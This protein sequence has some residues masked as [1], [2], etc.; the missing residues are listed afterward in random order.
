M[1][2][3]KIGYQ[4]MT[5][6]R[7]TILFGT[8]RHLII[9]F[10]AIILWAI[11]FRQSTTIGNYTFSAIIAYYIMVEIIDIFYTTTAGRLMARDINRGDLSNYLVKPMSYWGYLLGYS[12][13]SMTSYVSLS[14]LLLIGV[15]IIWPS[16]MLIQTNPFYSIATI[17]S[18]FLSALI[19]FQIFYLVGCLTFWIS[20]TN[21]FRSGIKQLLGVFGG[22][23]VPLSFFPGWANTLLAFTPFPLLF[24]SV[25]SIYQGRISAGEIIT[26]LGKELGWL[27]ILTAISKVIWDK[28]LQN[29]G[30]YGK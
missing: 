13:G 17:L 18:I 5:I 16:F 26:N 10:M 11:L 27:I 1:A 21:H 28:G 14:F 23:W 12:F 19:Y 30:A 6:Y 24:T 8:L 22:K 9:V 25:I 20:D 29:Y 7:S 4:L 3:F 15:I 2:F